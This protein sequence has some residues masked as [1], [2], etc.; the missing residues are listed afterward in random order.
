VGADHA[1]LAAALLDGPV[2][3]HVLAPDLFGVSLGQDYG[4]RFLQGGMGDPWRRVQLEPRSRVGGFRR[5]L[6]G[7]SRDV[8][9]VQGLADEFIERAGLRVLV[10]REQ[11][12][13]HDP[14]SVGQLAALQRAG[15]PAGDQTTKG[16]ASRLLGP[17][18]LNAAWARWGRF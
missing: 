9:V 7:T 1:A 11:A 12:W 17:M 14:A 8:D 6:R 2:S 10:D 5:R 15:I 13:H 18:Y 3:W 4:G 16:D